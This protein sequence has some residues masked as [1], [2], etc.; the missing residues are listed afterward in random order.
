[1]DKT[2]ILTAIKMTPR[3]PGPSWSE[4]WI[5]LW[6]AFLCFTT[7]CSLRPKP[8][9]D[10]QK[11][12]AT[13]LL[14]QGNA[15]YAKMHW[16]GWQKAAGHYE[17]L[18]GCGENHEVR[19]RLFLACILL[20]L[21]EAE[22]Q[23]PNESWLRKAERWLPGLPADPFSAYMSVAREKMRSILLF[24]SGSARRSAP[25]L[26]KIPLAV[27][28]ASPVS[29]F[30][31]LQHLSL[32]TGSDS[33]ARYITAENEFK[34]LHGDSNLA[35]FLSLYTQP[36]M[37]EKLAAC[38]DFAEMYFLRGN[39]L[40]N[41]KN[42]QAALAD[43]QR[44][45]EIMPIFF[46][47]RNA[48]ATLCY[49]LEEYEQALAHYR[50]TLEIFPL[51]RTALFGQGICLSELQ[52]YEQSDQA[53]SEMVA[54]QSFYHGEANYY[55]ARNSFYRQRPAETRSYLDLAAAY[56]PD[57]PELHMLSGLLYLQQGPLN[58][59]EADFR[60]VLEK[61]PR[62]GEAWFYLGQTVLRMKKIGEA[63]AYFKTS[64]ECFDREVRDFDAKLAVMG[65]ERDAGGQQRQLYLKKQRRRADYVRDLEGRLVGLQKTFD[66]P[67][68]P[69]LRELLAYL[70]APAAEK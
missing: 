25:D 29:H 3:S 36:E 34:K 4:R 48:M 35:V 5:P 57:A 54:K 1:M 60:K 49:S 14:E 30:L 70:A 67:P 45:V 19:Q 69:G 66:K 56:I 7:A 6:V 12:L 51:E 62:Q 61:D 50:Q 31:Y 28:T 2:E 15:E 65:R 27:D 9:A 17:R 59:A 21:R 22:L 53:L 38:P 39:L 26:G 23:V 40:Q 41:G 58:S 24:R 63:R 43:Y 55:L 47:A 18:L 8:Q 13:Q 37:D 11:A 10:P 33:T 52:R 20:S 42:Y 64:I 16:C 46:K 68:L 44:A 32:I